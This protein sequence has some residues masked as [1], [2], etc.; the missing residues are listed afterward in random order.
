MYG[1]LLIFQCFYTFIKILDLLFDKLD[2]FIDIIFYF[3]N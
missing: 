1:L 2:V 3:A